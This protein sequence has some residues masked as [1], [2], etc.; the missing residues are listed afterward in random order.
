MGLDMY[1]HS[2]SCAD[3]IDDFSFKEQ[4]DIDKFQY[5]RKHN[6]LHAWMEAL[7]RRKG[8]TKDS[9][10]C[11]YVR[12]TTE[13]LLQL[14]EDAKAKNLTPTAGYFF[15]SLQD[16]D[17]ECAQADIAFANKALAEISDGNAVYYFSW[18]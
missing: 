14:I 5:W 3:V 10:N 9:F 13:D 11:V 2:V 16:Y 8:G 17:E 18:W 12:L 6:A 7:Y 15:G 1:A 4:E